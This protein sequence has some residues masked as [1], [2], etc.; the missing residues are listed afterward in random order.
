MNA[1]CASTYCTEHGDVVI[2]KISQNGVGVFEELFEL[3]N[4]YE[5]FAV[6]AVHLPHA[7][8]VV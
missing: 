4:C 8:Y 1:F 5:L 3:I 2:F 7:I 6:L